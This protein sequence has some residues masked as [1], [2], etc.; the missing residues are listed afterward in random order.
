VVDDYYKEG[1][2]VNQKLERQQK[3]VAYGLSA[4]IELDPENGGLTVALQGD[5][6]FV[7]PSH[8][9]LSMHHATRSGHD[10][11]EQLAIGRDGLYNGPFAELVPGRWNVL[12][13]TSE[14]RIAGSLPWPTESNT[15]VLESIAGEGS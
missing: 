14:W 8:V 12:L 13:Q 1:L 3:A 10:Y 11:S 2:A 7:I 6:Q 4:I 5:E 9:D 15:L